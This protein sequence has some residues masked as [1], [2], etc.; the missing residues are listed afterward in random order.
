MRTMMRAFGWLM[1]V[2]AL[3]AVAAEHAAAQAELRR[4]VLAGGG[5]LMTVGSFT[6]RTTIGQTA[7]VR[8]TVRQYELRSGFWP[9]SG[10]TTTDVELAV[11]LPAAFELHQSWP[12]PFRRSTAIR[13]GVPAGGGRVRL[14]VFD[15]TGRRI[16]TLLDGEAAAGWQMTTWDG[17]DEGGSMVAT[18]VYFCVLETP[19]GAH[20]MKMTA[21]R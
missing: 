8:S 19:T 20:R 17:R 6:M 16:R 14:R 7:V 4:T 9:G 18:G 5:G 11:D 10:P 15:V 13:Y 2:G 21:L 1:L 12:N 3:A